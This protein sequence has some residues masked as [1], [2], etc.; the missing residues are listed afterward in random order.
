MQVQTCSRAPGHTAQACSS[1]RSRDHK[2]QPTLPSAKLPVRVRH[3]DRA[4]NAGHLA[5]PKLAHLDRDTT[6]FSHLLMHDFPARQSRTREIPSRAISF[7]RFRSAPEQPPRLQ[8]PL[9]PSGV[10]PRWH[11]EVGC[12][13]RRSFEEA[14]YRPRTRHTRHQ[15][16]PEGVRTADQRKNHLAVDACIGREIAA[17]D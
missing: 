16:Q 4:R 7:A 9:Q 1:D 11:G 2:A 17:S 13:G 12:P 6:H 15:E 8:Q 10:S 14:C 3:G 5:T